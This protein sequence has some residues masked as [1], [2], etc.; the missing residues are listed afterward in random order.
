MTG[1]QQEVRQKVS[2]FG[3]HIFIMDQRESSEYESEPIRIDQAF[4][5]S[6]KNEKGV[7]S[8]FPVAYKPV[9]FQSKKQKIKYTLPNGADTSEIQQNVFG[10]VIKGVEEITIEDLMSVFSSTVV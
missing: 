4:L 5:E 7:K 6:V 10:T 8:L 3:S 9:L 2:G 1:F